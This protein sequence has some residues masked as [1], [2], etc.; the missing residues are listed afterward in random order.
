MA[1]EVSLKHRLAF[2]SNQCVLKE[3]LDKFRMN[4]FTN[5]LIKISVQNFKNNF[6]YGNKSIN[7]PAQAKKSC[8]DSTTN[9]SIWAHKSGIPTIRDCIFLITQMDNEVNLNI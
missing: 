1:F 7:Y 6:F 3:E 2:R 5:S 9:I 4:I 8:F